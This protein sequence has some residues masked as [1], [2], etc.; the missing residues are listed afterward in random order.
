MLRNW[1]GQ[2]LPVLKRYR[3]AEYPHRERMM[4]DQLLSKGE[5]RFQTT[6]RNIVLPPPILGPDTRPRRLSS[7][8]SNQCWVSV[9]QSSNMKSM[10]C[11]RY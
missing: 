7:E 2:A 4:M 10:S 3:G 1:G 6:R 5:V 11:I 8:A 9:N